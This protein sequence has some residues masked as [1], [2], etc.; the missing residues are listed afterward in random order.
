MSII[1][2]GVLYLASIWKSP[3]WQIGSEGRQGGREACVLVG[4]KEVSGSG[5]KAVAAANMPC[6]DRLREELSCAVR[7]L[8]LFFFI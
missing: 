5:E 7:V 4:D 3:R 2:F 8:L 1:F 6:M